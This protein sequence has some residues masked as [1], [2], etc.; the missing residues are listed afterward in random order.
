MAIIH[1]SMEINTANGESLHDIC[2][3]I[4]AGFEKAQNTPVA[5]VGVATPE[6]PERRIGNLYNDI[7]DFLQG[8]ERYTRRTLKAIAK[9]VDF[10][11]VPVMECLDVLALQGAVRKSTRRRDGATLYELM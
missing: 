1:I 11:E 4:A 3:Q 6:V 2:R 7:T 8:D 10:D 5:S 9:G